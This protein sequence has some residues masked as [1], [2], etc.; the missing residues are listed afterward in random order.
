MKLHRRNFV[1]GAGLLAGLLPLGALRAGA[2]AEAADPA[3]AAEAGN[4]FAFEGWTKLRDEF[5]QDYSWA[6]FAG[7]LLASR[8]RMV[9]QEIAFHRAQLNRNAPNH[10][11]EVYRL[12]AEARAWAGRYFGV[13]P[14]QVSLTGNTTMGLATLYN[15]L[16]IRP[17]Q[18]ILS[19]E[20]E[21]YSCVT[22]IHYR[23]QREGIP[24]N[25]I[26]LYG[27]PRE[28][29]TDEMLGRIRKNVTSRTRVLALT[30]VHSG[31]SI[32]L[33]AAEVS[34]LVAELN[35][36]RGEDDRLLFCLDGVHGFGVENANFDELGCDFF[37]AG[38]HKWMFGP[39]GTGIMV[40]RDPRL[41]DI[42]PTLPPF[43]LSGEEGFG[44][45]L[46]PGGFHTFE[47]R[48]AQG[49]A[50]EF[51]LRIGKQGVQDRIRSLNDRLKNQLEELGGVELVTPLG[52]DRSAGF[53]FF[54]VAGKPAEQVQEIMKE[55]QVIVSAAD[56]DAGPVVRMAPGILNSEGEIDAAVEVLRK[57]G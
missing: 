21:H 10:L 19:T 31:S 44:A 20:H 36:G 2:G 26:R 38:T 32:K 17:G 23:S 16:R 56:R 25:T 6:N 45:N 15:G 50:F 47:N 12:E 8:P 28:A 13:G 40:A 27:E 1:K 55:H 22:S 33:P 18:E 3:K 52:S 39:S 57:I 48:C 7:F 53:T 41:V 30:W 51:H 24:V 54:R 29:S 11:P 35:Q 49:K 5:D 9:E 37:V 46:T 14:E 42:S 4:A 34:K 43:N